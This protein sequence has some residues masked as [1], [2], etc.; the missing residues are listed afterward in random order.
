MLYASITLFVV[1]CVSALSAVAVGPG[2]LSSALA[3]VGMFCLMLF[4]VTLLIS[5]M[6]PPQF[7]RGIQRDREWRESMV[8]RG[9]EDE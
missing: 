4:G 8:R 5:M 1:A 2:K 9:L 6:R 3:L 7:Y